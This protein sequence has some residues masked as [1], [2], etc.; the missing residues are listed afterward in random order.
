MN[1]LNELREHARSVGEKLV[2]DLRFAEVTT[3][4]W[5]DQVRSDLEVSRIMNSCLDDL[6]STSNWRV[7][8]YRAMNVRGLPLL[9]WTSTPRLSPMQSGD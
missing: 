8:N 2:E 6:A 9:C 7:V 5:S 3:N 4:A 1:A